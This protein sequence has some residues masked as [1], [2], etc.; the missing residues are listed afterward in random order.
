M[1]WVLLAI[2]GYGINAVVSLLD[3]FM[4]TA[5]KVPNPFM[6]AFYVCILSAGSILA[7]AADPLFELVG[8]PNLFPSWE[9]IGAPDFGTIALSLVV[10][11][12]VFLGLYMMY[13]SLRRKHASDVVPVI[14]SVAAVTALATELSVGRVLA[15]SMLIGVVLIVLGTLL[16]SH[17]R[18]DR[19]T[20][21]F[22]VGSGI[23][24]GLQTVLLSY[25]FERD[26][27]GG[28]L[29]SRLSLALVALVAYGFVILPYRKV[30]KK[31]RIA[32]RKEH[33]RGIAWVIANKV[34]AGFGA[35]LI[36]RAIEQG[37]PSVVQAL[38]GFQFLALLVLGFA[39]G[40]KT[41]AEYGEEY[42]RDEI[43]QK[44]VAVLLITAGMAFLFIPL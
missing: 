5:K 8:I 7:F 29:W 4:V 10:G 1:S 40:N 19:I 14:T 2:A 36:F 6:Y 23:A 24:F 35:I 25:L 26:F 16:I 3:R 34:L 37:S 21:A 38:S 42:T 15:D 31:P 43:A 33:A 12:T 44:V 28:F 18:F 20:R 27:D 22:A 17:F 9:G 41:P 30:T 32:T 39:F 13:E 11:A